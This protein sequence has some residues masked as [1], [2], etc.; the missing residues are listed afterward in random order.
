MRAGKLFYEVQRGADGVEAVRDRITEIINA[1]E[2]RFKGISQGKGETKAKARQ[3]HGSTM[4]QQE[5]MRKTQ[6]Q[7]EN[8][9]R[10]DKARQDDAR[11]ESARHGNKWRDTTR[12]N[13][14]QH[15][16]TITRPVRVGL[17]LLGLEL[18]LG[19]GLGLGAR[20]RV[21]VGVRVRVRVRIT[22]RFR[23]RGLG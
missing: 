10:Q 8:T 3:D 17:G 22:V 13:T 21:G 2:G 14:T 1:R 20:P 15:N 4:Q 16:A 9:T 23:V 11:N 6:E 19:L 7:C 12:H 5:T 18:G